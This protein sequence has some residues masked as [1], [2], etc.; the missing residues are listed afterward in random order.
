MK[1]SGWSRFAAIS[2]SFRGN[3]QASSAIPTLNLESLASTRHVVAP[4]NECPQI[5]GLEKSEEAG[6]YSFII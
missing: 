6:H 4:P 1:K 2:S 5:A 3:I